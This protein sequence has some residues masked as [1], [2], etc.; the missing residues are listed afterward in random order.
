MGTII[1]LGLL[2]MPGIKLSPLFLGTNSTD[3][4]LPLFIV[5]SMVNANKKYG[6][7]VTAIAM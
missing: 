1:V 2:G 4:S 5:I 7:V 6:Q 3:G